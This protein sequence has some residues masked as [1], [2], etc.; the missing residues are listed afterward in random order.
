MDDDQLR[1]AMLGG[2]ADARATTQRAAESASSRQQDAQ[3]AREAVEPRDLDEHERS[4]DEIVGRTKQASRRSRNLIFAGSIIFVSILVAMTLYLMLTTGPRLLEM[5]VMALL[6]VTLYGLIN[7]ATWQGD[8]PLKALREIDERTEARERERLRQL[9]R[10]R[11]E[12]EAERKADRDLDAVLDE[13]D[14]DDQPEATV[15]PDKTEEEVAD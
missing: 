4:D 10:R 5:F 13:E 14:P 12:R 1:D 7:A 3:R 9:E 15:A 11:A 8:D 2:E 6:L